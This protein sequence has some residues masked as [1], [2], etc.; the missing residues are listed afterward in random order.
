MSALSVPMAFDYSHRSAPSSLLPPEPDD[1]LPDVPGPLYAS[2]QPH[3]FSLLA[4]LWILADNSLDGSHLLSMHQ[5]LPS[6][7]DY[8]H[9]VNQAGT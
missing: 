4:A 6:F 1:S 7:P 9:S 3:P 8:F 2:P 5:P